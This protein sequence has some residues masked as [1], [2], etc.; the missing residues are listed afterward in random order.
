ML[1]SACLI[2]KDEALTIRKCLE[3]L[4][5]V[6]DEVIVLDTGSR[7][8]TPEHARELGARVYEYAWKQ[9]FADAR[10]ESMKYAHGR[11]IL[12]IDADEYL[13]ADEKARIRPFLEGTDAEGVLIQVQNYVGHVYALQAASLVSVVRIFKRGYQFTGAI[14]EQITAAV[15]ASGKPLAHLDLTFHHL[16]YLQEFVERRN[17]YERNRTMLEAELRREPDNLFHQIN[18]MAELVRSHEFRAC[19]R[20]GKDVYDRMKALPVAQ[21]PH[22]T[23]RVAIILPTALWEDGRLEEAVATALELIPLFPWLIELKQRCAGMLS[24]CDRT[25]EAI[26]LLM[27]CRAAGDARESYIDTIHGI[28]TYISAGDLG[29]AYLRLGDTQ[30][31]RRWLLTSFVESPTLFTVIPHLLHLLPPDPKFLHEQFESRI[32]APGVLG[33]YAE[34]YATL[35]YP[36]APAVIERAERFG[37]SEMTTRARAVHFVLHEDSDFRTFVENHPFPV[38][39]LLYAFTCL[40]KGDEQGVQEGLAASGEREAQARQAVEGL[41]AGRPLNLLPI[42]RELIAVRAQR[43]L[44]R[45]LVY[46]ADLKDVWPLLESSP[47]SHVLR[48]TV[49]PG[50]DCAECEYNALRAFRARDLPEA[51]RWLNAGARFEPTVRRVILECDVAM[52]Q[53]QPEEA[54][55]TL[56]RGGILFPGSDLIRHVSSNLTSATKEETTPMQDPAQLYLRQMTAT[57]PLNIQLAQLHERGVVLTRQ[58]LA[59]HERGEMEAARDKIRQMEDILTF[60]RGSLDRSLE[61]SKVTDQTYSFFYNMLVRWYLQ[62]V[63]IP[64]EHKTLLEFWESWAQTWRKTPSRTASSG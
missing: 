59:D 39:R 13:D 10:N 47:F 28:G 50:R 34:T 30:T 6:A 43:T 21:W 63:N 51:R 54:L 3:S 45:M 24:A 12:F 58:T 64:E 26:E 61:I 31:A 40:E 14:H 15:M 8:D 32:H 33:V 1:L 9:D 42:L 55:R 38:S 23:A 62:P 49:W 46:A 48:D 18:L 19:W 41:A 2:V 17:K 4:V 36:D 7:D 22:Y 35:D 29:Q 27:Q 60:L 44:R 56:H 16:G 25:I 53:G 37:N 57:A 52:A 11:Y 20:L 5:G